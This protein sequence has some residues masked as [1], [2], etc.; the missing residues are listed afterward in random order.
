MREDIGVVREVIPWNST[1][2]RDSIRHFA[3]GIGDDN[4]LWWKPE[5]GTRVLAP[6]TVLYSC[7][8]GPIIPGIAEGMPT[9]STWLPG[10]LGL[11]ASDKWKWH[12]PILEGTDVR[13]SI[14]LLDANFRPTGKLGPSVRQTTRTTFWNSDETALAELDRTII[15]LEPRPTQ[16][17]PDDVMSSEP[18]YSEEQ[19][20]EIAAHYAN[21]AAQRRGTDI[22]PVSSVAMGDS[23]PTLVKGPLTVTNLIGWLLG[24]GS[25]LNQTNRILSSF[26]DA[27]PG[28]AIRHPVSN[29]LD[30]VEAPHWDAMLARSVGLPRGFDFGGQRISWMLHVVTDWC[31]DA[32]VV[33]E[34]NARLLAANLLG[35][36]QW[37][38]GEVAEIGV[39]GEANVVAIDLWSTSQA[40]I[41]TADA[42]ALVRLPD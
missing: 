32:G 28:A 38:S 2:S 27:S 15:R 35:D 22:R 18:A 34:L 41:R 1:I 31:G 12:R 26:F 6:P 33:L 36:T 42:R 25:A 13:V 40:G 21:E 10:A 39:D 11:W 37:L 17:E 29:V 16:N 5:Q 19:H 3:L 24:S 7:A 20:S 14:A 8:D 30:T 23:L 9:S 4:P